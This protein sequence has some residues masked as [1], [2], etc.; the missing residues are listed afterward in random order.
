MSSTAAVNEKGLWKPIKA[1]PGQFFSDDE[2]AKSK[3]YQRPL[4]Y[5]RLAN[6]LV[7]L[8]SA[9]VFIGAEMPR[10]AI[11]ASNLDPWPLQLMVV[12]AAFMAMVMIVTLPIGIWSEFVHEKKW[13][14]STQTPRIFV[15]DQ[16]KGFI[17][18]F[19]LFG[20]LFIPT[21]A[22]IRRSELWWIYGAGVFVLFTVILAFLLPVVIL[23]I[24]NKFTSLDKEELKDRLTA[25]AEKAGVKI[26][27]YQVMDASKRT[28]KDN[29]FF[30]GLGATRRVVVFD[31]L[32][33]QPEECVEVV[34]AHEIGHWRRGHVKKQLVL[35]I[36]LAL[37]L[38]GAVKLITDWGAAMDFAGLRSVQDP[39][40]WPLWVTAFGVTSSITQFVSVWFSRWFERQ[41][42]LDA[43]ELTENPNAY[44]NLWKNFTTRNLPDLDP[45][46]WHRIKEDHPP[47]AERMAFAAQWEE[48]RTSG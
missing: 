2:V 17:L 13:G 41:A 26:T 27:D 28:K 20:A 42:D 4:Q 44:A 30:A 47:I 5:A 34:V 19:V 14:F 33:E 24:F 6:A 31:N 48:A 37:T 32:L 16:I 38:F 45:S 21:W 15:M 12:I 36:L 18:A 22:L 40:A 46:W 29:A 10:K 23:P 43:L 8:V 25:L 3:K 7:T 9:L 11:E 1:D 39:A 35:G